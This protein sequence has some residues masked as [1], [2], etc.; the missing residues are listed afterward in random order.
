[1]DYQVHESLDP[2]NIERRVKFCIIVIIVAVR[3]NNEDPSPVKDIGQ[4]SSVL[5]KLAKI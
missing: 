3:K 1:M 2:N 4:I 5:L